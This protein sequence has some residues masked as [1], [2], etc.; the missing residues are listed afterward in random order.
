MGFFGGLANITGLQA[1]NITNNPEQAAVGANTPESTY[2]MNQT[3]APILNKHYTPT[4]NMTGGYTQG[5]MQQNAAQGYS[6]TG[7]QAANAVG[8][9]VAEYMTAGAATPLIAGQAAADRYAAQNPRSAF[10]QQYAGLMANPN[11]NAGVNAQNADINLANGVNKGYS[12]SSYNNGGLT[13]AAK[14][15]QAK[16]RGQD[17]HLVHMTAGELNA[18]QK[19]ANQ[20][21]GSLSINP[22]TGLPEAGFLSSAL[23]MVL[24]AAAAMT[25]QEWAVP[26]AMAMSAGGEYAMTG[27]L[28][29]GL[30]AGL[31]AWGGASL[32]DSLGSAG[33]E[34]TAQQGGDTAE[35]AFN[36]Q[37]QAVQETANKAILDPNNWGETPT[38]L[39]TGSINPV[40]QA[41]QA[42]QQMPNL[43]ADQITNMTANLTPDNAGSIVKAAGM[44]NAAMGAGPATSLSN[45][46]AGLSNTFSSGTNALNFA[47]ANPSSVAMLGGTALSALGAFNQP[48]LPVQTS[49]TNPFNIKPL[50]SNF[51]G[52]YPAQPQPYY[53]AQYPNYVQSPYSMATAK[54]GGIMGYSGAD[55]SEVQQGLA[56]ISKR[57][58][59]QATPE[60]DST[61][62]DIDP[63]TKNLDAYNTAIKNL[64]KINKLAHLAPTKSGLGAVSPL[65]SNIQ[66]LSQD[67]LAAEAATKDIQKNSPVVNT[68]KEGGLQSHLGDYSDGGRL[69]KGPGDGVS[70]GIPAVIGGKQPARL[71]DGEFVIP[72]RIVSELGNGSTDAGAKRLY[73]MMDRIKA[74]RRKAKDIAADTKAYKHLPA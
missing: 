2:A 51:Q 71:A 29:Q 31:G 41:Q 74:A 16:G 7:A 60:H 73:A 56:M 67:Q 61:Y 43:T 8:N 39:N 28:T 6:N 57:P 22:H 17:T 14:H 1:A 30:M 52:Q 26:L 46:G 10:A 11:V 63:D 24:G 62:V 72:A 34:A 50:S 32:A 23:P 69:L 42:I 66:T 19:L 44:A 18:M 53:Q 15:L 70:D 33:L 37:Q 47:K 64:E 49:Q 58:V 55:G 59:L 40:A 27:S 21:G 45:M 5:E 38:T 9:A 68:A 36:A 3:V 35:K 12:M 65:G 13:A 4:I 48:T 20:H 25:G 54:S